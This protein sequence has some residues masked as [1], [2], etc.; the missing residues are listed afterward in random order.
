MDDQNSKLN[1]FKAFMFNDAKQLNTTDLLGKIVNI[2]DKEKQNKKILSGED[3]ESEQS[4][5]NYGTKEK[6]LQS[7]NKSSNTGNLIQ[8]MFLAS[9][10]GSKPIQVEEV[11]RM[12]EMTTNNNTFNNRSRKDNE[13]NEVKR[14]DKDELHSNYTTN[15]D[16]KTKKQV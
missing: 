12:V 2:I 15:D 10:G 1:K 7:S 14:N 11:Q 6:T 9:G 4:E 3:I 8:Q 5:V 13:I 16:V